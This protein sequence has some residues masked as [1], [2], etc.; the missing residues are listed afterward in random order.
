MGQAQHSGRMR[1]G[2]L[3]TKT[4]FKGYGVRAVGKAPSDKL[5]IV[6]TLVTPAT[7]IRPARRPGCFTP[8][9]WSLIVRIRCGVLSVFMAHCPNLRAWVS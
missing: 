6:A 5:L 9:R 4:R 1:N 8:V 7:A 3:A 2:E